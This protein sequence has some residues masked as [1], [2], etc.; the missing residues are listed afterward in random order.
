MIGALLGAIAS[1]A[2]GVIGAQASKDAADQNYNMDLLN[3]YAR[4][5]ERNDAIT[6][7]KQQDRETKLGSTDAQ[8]NRTFFKP[9]VGWVVELSDGSQRLADLYQNEELQQLQHDLPMKRERMNK[10]DVRQDEESN[11]ADALLNAFRRT[12]REDPRDLEN[13]LNQA[14][15]RGITQGFDSTLQDAMQ[16]AARTGASNSG[17]VAA[18]IGKARASALM[19]AFMNNK[20][21]SQAQSRDNY[22]QDQANTGNLYN[23]FATRASA[24]PDVQYNPRNLEGMTSA[25]MQGAQGANQSAVGALINAFAKQ[26]GTMSMVEPDYGLANAVASGGNALAGAFERIGAGSE[27]RSAIDAYANYAG[28]DPSMYKKSTGAW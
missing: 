7:S 1:V 25:Q 23:M 20:I 11:V 27:R 18:E 4:E 21:N 8:G 22:A 5:R 17:K 2:S 28:L 16:S 6:R 3:Y 26:G 13:Q 14:S 12:T 10:N 24:M 9:G 19:D 15:V